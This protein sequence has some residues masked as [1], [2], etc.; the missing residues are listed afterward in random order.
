MEGESLKKEE[1]CDV[2]QVKIAPQK[3]EEETGVAKED[4]SEEKRLHRIRLAKTALINL[5]F[6]VGLVSPKPKISFF[7]GDIAFV[8]LRA[9]F[10]RQYCCCC[11]G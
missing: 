8:V 5:S 3:T 11:W 2:A 10:I 7:L 9:S 1:E 6:I 4:S